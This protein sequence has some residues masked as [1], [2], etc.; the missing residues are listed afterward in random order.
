M[1]Q[2]NA[3]GLRKVRGSSVRSAAAAAKPHGRH[4]VSLLTQFGQMR[5]MP[6]CTI[7]V[8]RPGAPARL[9]RA[10]LGFARAEIMVQPPA[11]FD[12]CARL[13]APTAGPTIRGDD[14]DRIDFS[15]VDPRARAC[16]AGRRPQRLWLWV[17]QQ[18]GLKCR[19][20]REAGGFQREQERLPSE[21]AGY[22][23]GGCQNRHQ[24]PVRRQATVEGVDHPFSVGEHQSD[25]ADNA[26]DL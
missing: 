3:I 6:P 15:A 12:V 25:G 2:V 20:E 11:V 23:L 9:R 22:R 16:R 14:R 8:R 24:Q 5:Y 18:R 4:R 10:R 7:P 19:E 17:C 1:S 26:C 21:L 13:R